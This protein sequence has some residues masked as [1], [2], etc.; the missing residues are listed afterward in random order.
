[1][2]EKKSSIVSTCIACCICL[3]LLVIFL[4]FVFVF[5]A[6]EPVYYQTQSETA[7]A[8][9]A[10]AAVGK[11]SFTADV[12]EVQTNQEMDMSQYLQCEGLSPEDVVWSSDSDRLTVGSKGHIVANDYGMD[13]NLVASSKTDEAVK[14]ACVIRS[15]TEAEDFAWQ[16]GTLNGEEVPEDEAAEDGTM[17]LAYS[18]EDARLIDVKGTEH[19]PGERNAGYT[20][21]RKLFY[22]LEDVDPDSDRDGQINS[23]RVEKKKFIDRETGNEIEYEI[24]HEPDTDMIHKIV[25]IEYRPGKLAIVEYYYTNQ[26]K[27]NF[28]YAYSDVNYTPS[29]ATPDRDGERYLYHKDTLVT[30]RIVKNGKMTNYCCGKAEKKRLTDG[31]FPNVTLYSDCSKKRK[32][33]YDKKEKEI[34]NMAYNVLDAAM[35]QE[36]ISTIS[37]YI[38]EPS[39]EGLSD[40]EVSL[41]SEEYEE[42]LC[43]VETDEEGYYEIMVPTKEAE[44]QLRFQKDGYIEETLYGIEANTSEVSLS[45]EAVCLSGEDENEYDCELT[46]YDALNK[47]SDGDGMEELEEPLVIIRRG[48]GNRT[49]DPVFRGQ[50]SGYTQN[51]SLT[52]G[53]YTVQMSRDGYMDT[54][55][56]LFVSRETG[57]ELAVYATPELKE[58]EYRIVLTWNEEP[59]DLDSHLFVPADTGEEEDYHICYYHMEDSDGDHSLDVDDT[60]GYGPETTTVSHI[61]RG[62]YKFYVC[63]YTN[64]SQDN[65]KSTQ[66]SDSSAAVR[67]YGSQ[68]LIQ[69]FYVPVH[70]SGVIWEVF[71]IR[72]GTVIPS[73]R[74][75]DAIGNRSWWR[76]E[77]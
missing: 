20:W 68:G 18:G 60:D 49:G 19:E 34:L 3:V 65:E 32:K 63:D 75:Y 40:T 22:K 41:E 69:T 30:W 74:Y 59:R 1:M 24:Y 12:Y 54:Y 51:V 56:S 2:H 17:R 36:G 55:S 35:N 42:P 25:S 64:C 52:P 71:E 62:Q 15:G 66:M 67:V 39:G 31:G 33:Q 38:N 11:L 4:L 58:D 21:D 7:K 23:Y 70:R 57:N 10:D 45:Q 28:V 73:Q 9:N 43:T 47:A 53:M 77:K 14:A 37:G 61:R 13:C 44:Y 50:V 8:G 48:A 6:E 46:F 5:G 26:G 72:D 76:S 16:V 29:Y 27:V